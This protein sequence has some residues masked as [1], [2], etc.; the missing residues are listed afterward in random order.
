MRGILRPEPDSVPLQ[1]RLAAVPRDGLP[2]EAPVSIRWNDQQ[3]PFI[4]AATDHDLAVA[5]GVVHVHLR[6]TQLELMRHVVAGRISEL[7]G[8]FGIGMDR[9]LRTLDLPRAVPAIEA[10][11]PDETRAWIEAFVAGM[12]AAAE[13]L[14]AVPPEFRWLGLRRTPWTV[15]DVLAT[16]RLAALDVTWVVWLALL[17]QRSG[18]GAEALWRRLLGHS[19]GFDL[20]DAARQDRSILGLMRFSRP[21]SNAWAVAPAR[22]ATGGAWMANDTHLS[23]LL[24]NLWLL[25]G[26]K[27]PSFHLAGLMV[28]G[29]PAMLIGRNPHIAWGGTNLHAA[30]SDLFDLSEVPEESLTTRREWVRVRGMGR[31]LIKVRESALGPVLSDLPRLR[32]GG[33]GRYALRWMGHRA[34]DELT[35]LMG[36]NRARNWADFRSALNAIGVPGQNILY[37]DAEGHIAKAMAAHL[38]A[39]PGGCAAEPLLPT[40]AAAAWETVVRSEDLPAVVDPPEGFIASANDKPKEETVRIGYF[41]SSDQR[42]NR[43]SALLAAKEKL[44]FTTLAA[45]QRDVSVPYAVP[46]AGRLASL[47]RQAGTPQAVQL[48]TAL[49]GWDGHYGARAREPLIFELLL[50]QLGRALHGKQMLRLYS[51]VWNT[52]GL[53]ARDLERADQALLVRLLRGVLPKVVRGMLRY[54]TWGGMHRV[55]PRHPFAGVPVLGRRFDFAGWPAD[56]GNDTIMKTAYALSGRRHHATL[57][58]TARHLSDLSDMD[59]NWFVLMGGQD[60]WLGS[61]TL[62]DQTRQW[63][64]GTYIQ[65]PLRPETVAR[66]FP[67]AMELRP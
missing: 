66:L 31:R 22:S 17:P 2:L 63:R 4:E 10:M 57:A 48:A 61:T 8:P 29:V 50:Y 56:G 44:D 45:M 37:A 24:P 59:S 41:F 47:L 23:P 58:S 14:P 26:G 38:P 9:M 18:R 64:E 5:L 62:V 49:E 32:R 13:R 30:S 53:L 42:V 1:A 28:P 11:L 36:M 15:R 16:T 43:I 6:W 60:G 39:R 54:R 51:A 34:S 35:G 12:N 21:G 27:S 33:S 20:A 19:T 52:R 3:V 46:V 65:M 67:H 25:A 55:G 7:A 40:S